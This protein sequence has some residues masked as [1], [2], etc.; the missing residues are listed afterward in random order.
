MTTTKSRPSLLLKD[1]YTREDYDILFKYLEA[2]KTLIARIIKLYI[3]HNLDIIKRGINS[4]I[5]AEVYDV[6]YKTDLNDLPLLFN[7]SDII[8]M[9]CLWRFQINK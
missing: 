6:M 5:S 1:P 9:I 3:V 7:A 8:K 2:D 4:K